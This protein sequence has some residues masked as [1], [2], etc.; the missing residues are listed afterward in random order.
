[1]GF[2]RRWGVV[3]MA[4][5]SVLL[6]SSISRL[7]R[8]SEGSS[9]CKVTRG[10][11]RVPATRAT[12]TAARCE[13]QQ[14]VEGSMG[15]NVYLS[16]LPGGHDCRSGEG[17]VVAQLI[18]FTRVDVVYFGCSRKLLSLPVPRPRGL[19]RHSRD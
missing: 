6:H 17:D 13:C 7:H 19:L 4:S 12:G 16:E 10:M 5:M 2:R 1:M 3:C 8:T 9:A 18:A 14:L 15:M 11:K